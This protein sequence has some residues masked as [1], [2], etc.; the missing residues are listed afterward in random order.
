MYFHDQKYGSWVQTQSSLF[1]QDLGVIKNFQMKSENLSPLPV[2]HIHINRYEKKPEASYGMYLS[3]IEYCR[4]LNN[5]L[6]NAISL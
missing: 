5:I 3:L 2:M 1:P 4:T 6:F